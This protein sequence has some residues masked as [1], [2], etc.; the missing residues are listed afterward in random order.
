MINWQLLRLPVLVATF[1]GVA[2]TF[3]K[4]ALMPTPASRVI[5][6][7]RSVSLEGWQLLSSTAISLEDSD[8]TANERSSAVPGTLYRYRQGD[9]TLNI[10]MRYLVDDDSEVRNLMLK[11]GK[12]SAASAPATVQFQEETGFVSLSSDQSHLYLSSCINPRGSTTV[13]V[14][15]FNQ[16]RYAHDLRPDRVLPVLLGQQSLRDSRCLWA[17]MTLSLN[18]E[19]LDSAR[20]VLLDAWKE[21]VYWWQP[22]FPEP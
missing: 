20:Q 14:A 17:H 4:V 3:G 21:W 22:R 6:L 11:Y 1:S 15:Q 5:N 7:P 2:L 16:N 9:R 13:T 10:E 8:S 12:K 18:K 19:N